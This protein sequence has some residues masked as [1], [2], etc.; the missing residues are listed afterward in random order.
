[1]QASTDIGVCAP[2]ILLGEAVDK[3]LAIRG[4]DKKKYYSRY[5]IV[6]GEIWKDIFQKTLWATKSVWKELKEDS[7]Y[8]SIDIPPDCTRLFSVAIADECGLIQPL[9]YNSQL[10]ILPKPTTR[11]CGCSCGECDVCGD[12]NAMSVTTKELFTINGTIYYEK[13]WLKYCSN[14]DI[15]EYT[16]TPTKKYNTF[17]GD[18]GDYNDDY[19]NDYDIGS[20]PLADFTIVT[21]TAQK[22]VC[23]LATKPCGCPQQTVENECIISEY[24]GCLLPLFSCRKDRHRK[25]FFENVNNNHRGEVK[26]SECETKIFYNPSKKWRRVTNAQHPDF[27]L[28][29]YQSNGIE[30]GQETQVPEYAEMALFAGIDWLSKQFNGTYSLL[31]KR[32][33]KAFYNDQQ[34]EV[35]KF[36]NPLSLERINAIQDTTIK[37]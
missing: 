16:E 31:E 26:I 8:P 12:I 35:I 6:A 19:N 15:L 20:N 22:K 28:V 10:N 17:T 23:T 11:N 27:L 37:W 36:L 5:L 34:S 7:P 18:G 29:N 4:V 3:Y 25:Q 14:G 13:T 21:V 9:Y 30:P 33:A 24:C 32:E 2:V 1:M